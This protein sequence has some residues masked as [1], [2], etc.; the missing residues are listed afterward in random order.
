MWFFKNLLSFFSFSFFREKEREREGRW[1]GEGACA[2]GG[3]IVSSGDRMEDRVT[4]QTA[5]R[6]GS[7]HGVPGPP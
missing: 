6:A 5:K 1:K 4:G 2:L 3:K 7:S